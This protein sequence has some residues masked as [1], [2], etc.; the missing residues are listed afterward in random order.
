MLLLM[1]P[2]CMLGQ[3]LDGNEG[4]AQGALG[5]IEY[6]PLNPVITAQDANPSDRPT[7]TG[8]DGQ[9]AMKCFLLNTAAHRMEP[10]GFGGSSPKEWSSFG[11]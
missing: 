1:A 2:M 7:L 10:Q 6:N 3:E 11:M 8:M 4:Y 5:Y 9:D